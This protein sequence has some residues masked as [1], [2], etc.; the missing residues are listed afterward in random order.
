RRRRHRLQC[1]LMSA[2]KVGA[3]TKALLD[4]PPP[5]AV[6]RH[7]YDEDAL[8]APN[9]CGYVNERDPL[10]A[11]LYTEDDH[12]TEWRPEKDRISDHSFSIDAAGVLSMYSIRDDTTLALLIYALIEARE[13]CL[14]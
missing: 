10:R 13:S 11:G 3:R 4:L 1:W 7:T 14:A 8:W 5:G 12:Y 2:S 9:S 6:F